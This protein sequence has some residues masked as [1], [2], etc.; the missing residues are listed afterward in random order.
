MA[1]EIL[2]SSCY[3]STL[4]FHSVLHLKV[5]WLTR[6][7]DGT[8][9]FEVTLVTI[10]YIRPPHHGHTKS[11]SWITHILFVHCQSA[12]PFL[13]KGY[14]RLWPWNSKVKGMGVVKGQGHTIGPV[15]YQLTSSSF[16]IN[17]TNNSGDRAILKLDLETSK[18]VEWS[19]EW[20]QRSRSYIVPSIQPMH[21]LFVSHQSD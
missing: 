15:S 1:D 5:S 10:R 16:H 11:I 19:K 2:L 9:K 13:R 8:P 17:Q 4:R 14:F 7:V 21:F 12:A 6:Y 3:R 20:G 18:V